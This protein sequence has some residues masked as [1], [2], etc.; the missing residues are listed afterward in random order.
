MNCTSDLFQ[1]D[2]VFLFFNF[3]PSIVPSL[4]I[5]QAAVREEVY[6]ARDPKNF[7]R[8]NSFASKLLT[9]YAKFVL[10]YFVFATLFLFFSISTR[11]QE[12]YAYL[13]E[14]LSPH[15]QSIIRRSAPGSPDALDFEIDP[16]KV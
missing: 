16:L 3:C 15:V 4:P 11:S 1:Y 8:Q 14:V 9:N 7:L 5:I 13:S 12:G 2:L 10:S 6:T